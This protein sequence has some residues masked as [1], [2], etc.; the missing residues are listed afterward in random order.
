LTRPADA[1]PATRIAGVEDKVFTISGRL[2]S[3]QS[4]DDSDCRLVIE[5]DAHNSILGGDSVAEM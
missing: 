3:F 5:D 1:L 4:D 2:K